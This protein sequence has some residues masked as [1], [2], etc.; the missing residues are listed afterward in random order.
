MA[1]FARRVGK[2]SPM[3]RY[4]SP[5]AILH[6]LLEVLILGVLAAGSVILD[7]APGRTGSEP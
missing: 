2:D 7:P 3:T 6:W 1:Q 5:V 4:T